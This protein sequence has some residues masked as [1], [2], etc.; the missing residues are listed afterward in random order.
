MTPEIKRSDFSLNC[1][2]IDDVVVVYNAHSEH[3]QTTGTSKCIKLLH[4]IRKNIQFNMA[5]EAKIN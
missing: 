1:V 3:N 2:D 4:R 5:N